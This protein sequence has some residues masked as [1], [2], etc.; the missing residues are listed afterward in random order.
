MKELKERSSSN[1][2]RR[3]KYVCLCRIDKY[4]TTGALNQSLGQFGS[5]IVVDRRLDCRHKLGMIPLAVQP[6]PVDPL[7]VDLGV[8]VNLVQTAIPRVA[9]HAGDVHVKPLDILIIKHRSLLVPLHSWTLT[10]A[11]RTM[12]TSDLC[13]LYGQS[14][15][16][17]CRT[18]S[19]RLR[20]PSPSPARRRTRPR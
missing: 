8:V 14:A 17:T 1:I 18:H 2:F 9:E 16:V 13:P 11:P 7:H 20:C 5:G 19:S 15:D 6:G 4:L 3:Q 10:E 12:F